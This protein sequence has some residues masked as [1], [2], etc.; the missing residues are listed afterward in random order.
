MDKEKVINKM[1]EL[2]EMR[3]TE[4]NKV[5]NVKYLGNIKIEGKEQEIYLLEEQFENR[6]G[7]LIEVERY[8]TG[9]GEFLAGNNR[10]DQYNYLILDEK[11]LGEK[12][13]SDSLKALDKEGM[14]DLNELEQDRIKEIAEALG[15]EVEDIEEIDEI[16]LELEEKEKK[17]DTEEKEKDDENELEEISSK[18]VDG[19]NIKEE[20]SATVDIKGESLAD[21]LGLKEKGITDVTKIARV[22]TTSLNDV[23][24]ERNPNK[25]AFV[26]I[27]SN[28]KAVVL[29]ED[30]LKTDTRR[31]NNPRGDSLTI[32]HDGSV[33]E[34]QITT[35]YLIVNGNGQEYL[36]CGY[37]ESSGKEIKYSMRSNETGEDVAIELQT[38]RTYEKTS[39]VR[40]FLNDEHEGIYEPDEIIERDK[41]HGK[42]EEKDVTNIDNDKDNDSHQ[43]HVEEDYFQKCVDEIME[44]SDIE[45]IFTR[46]EVEESLRKGIEKAEEGTDITQIKEKVEKELEEDTVHYRSSEK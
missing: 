4:T 32:N 40:E 23:T 42:C 39:K 22:S 36:Q 25:D 37:D 8:Y 24:K 19:L 29:G 7:E 18:E 16:D 41:Q 12:E 26:A 10:E 46:R 13:L 31:G 15:V 2:R 28:G 44:N 6:D 9:E 35:S 11:Y 17:D 38:Q 5:L 3:E 45:E 21:K 30:I 34:E 43:P 14:L 33:N 1:R 27:K 20:T